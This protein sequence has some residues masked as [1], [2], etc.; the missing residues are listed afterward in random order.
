MEVAEVRAWLAESYPIV[1]ENFYARV[2]GGLNTMRKTRRRQAWDAIQGYARTERA[3]AWCD[4]F[5]MQATMRFARGQH[6]REEALWH[7]QQFCERM[8]SLMDL[9]EEAG[10]SDNFWDESMTPLVE[11]LERVNASLEAEQTSELY[12]RG[13]QIR[14]I[15]PRP[16]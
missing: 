12:L 4:R 5:G 3:Q 11:S 6:G 10:E 8:S 7:A 15:A 9:W 2:L 14:A 1:Y 13:Q 16:A